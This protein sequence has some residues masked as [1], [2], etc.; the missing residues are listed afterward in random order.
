MLSLYKTNV[1]RVDQDIKKM[2]E[3]IPMREIKGMSDYDN[4]ED[5]VVMYPKMHPKWLETSARCHT[6]VVIPSCSNSPC[7]SITDC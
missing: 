3:E 7:Y 2:D 5:Q 1:R 4:A 6:C